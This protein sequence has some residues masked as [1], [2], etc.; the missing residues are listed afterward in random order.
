M[1]LRRY[2]IYKLPGVARPVYLFPADGKYYLYDYKYG[3]SV[4]PR[5]VIEEDGHLLNWHGDQM[6]LTIEDLEDT[7]D[8]YNHL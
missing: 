6:S 5:F 8:S 1:S 7:G 3:L 2:G 4:P